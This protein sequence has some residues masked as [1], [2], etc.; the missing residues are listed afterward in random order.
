[1]QNALKQL[2]LSLPPRGL[3][4]YDAAAYVGVSPSLFDQMVKDRRMPQPKRINN[5][6]VWDRHQLDA[7]FEVLPD[8]NNQNPWDEVAV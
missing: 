2:P 4:R 3:S 5:R 6:T 1:M 7:A 8:S